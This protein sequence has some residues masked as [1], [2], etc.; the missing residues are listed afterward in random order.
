ML[1]S[2]TL[3]QVLKKMDFEK[4]AYDLEIEAINLKTALNLRRLRMQE[5]ASSLLTLP[6]LNMKSVMD[7]DIDLD[8]ETPSPALVFLAKYANDTLSSLVKVKLIAIPSEAVLQ[9]I[10]VHSPTANPEVMK[11]I[12]DNDLQHFRIA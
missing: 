7:E 12:D 3:E 11:L 8:G 10:S 6:I 5:N 1:G 4:K 2:F 9:C